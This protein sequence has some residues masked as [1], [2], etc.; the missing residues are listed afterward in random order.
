MASASLPTITPIDV[1]SSSRLESDHVSSVYESIAP[2]FSQTRYKPWPRVETFI[3][4]LPPHSLI[5]DVGC[6][7]G[8]YLTLNTTG[9]TLGCDTCYQLLTRAK[10]HT[11]H[12]F[13][14]DATNIQMRDNT[15]DAVLSIAVIHH[16]CSEERRVKALREMARVLVPGGRMLVYVWAMEQ[17]RRRFEAQDVLVPWHMQRAF[18][19]SGKG[20]GNGS[21]KRKKKRRE[22]KTKIV[23]NKK[24]SGEVLQ[25]VEL[26]ELFEPVNSDSD[27]KQENEVID[28]AVHNQEPPLKLGDLPTEIEKRE[29]NEI[30]GDKVRQEFDTYMR[31]YHVFREK[32][33]KEL[34]EKH[35]SN[36]TVVDS[37]YDHDNWCIA[38][39]KVRGK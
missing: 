35:V 9:I 10:S 21:G 29:S 22:K 32:E 30:A 18:S 36:V 7:N 37:Y 26:C 20:L 6:G 24:K 8:K 3:L 5:A 2:H 28:E 15:C 33:L 1:T 11:S 17:E 27:N 13:L 19:E 34:V 23:R 25:E 31:Y 14:A 12:L 38:A 16:L 4:S 39:V